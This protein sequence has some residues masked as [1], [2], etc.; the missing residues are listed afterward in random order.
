MPP[1]AKFSAEK[2]ILLS[3]HL[4][5]RDLLEKQGEA[6]SARSEFHKH[7]QAETCFRRGVRSGFE[8]VEVLLIS[9][10]KTTESQ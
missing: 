3:L 8:V 2:R 4:S 10:T 7:S 1:Q 6:I 9:K 5:S